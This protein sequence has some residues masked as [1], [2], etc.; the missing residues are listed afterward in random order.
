VLSYYLGIEVLQSR[1]AITI[2][3]GAYAKKIL[4]TIGLEESNPSRTPMEP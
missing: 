3:Q 1:D 4:D 2:C